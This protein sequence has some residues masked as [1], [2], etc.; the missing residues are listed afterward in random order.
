MTRSAASFLDLALLGRHQLAAFAATLVDFS[1]MIAFVEL[2][3]APPP[4]A[5]FASALLGGVTNFMLSRVWAYRDR[6]DGSVH[7][8]AAGYAAVSLGGAALNSILLAI[9]MLAP[10]PYV[11]GR[12]VV[13]IAVSL[14]YTYPLHTRFVFRVIR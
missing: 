4:I 1:S 5:T 14:F 11:I 8:Q 2:A 10:L 13:S 12:A 9:V 6:H 3:G 7:G